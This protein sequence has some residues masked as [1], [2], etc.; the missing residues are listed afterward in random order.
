MSFDIFVITYRVTN[1]CQNWLTCY[2]FLWKKTEFPF[3]VFSCF[4]VLPVNCISALFQD[5][6]HTRE[7]RAIALASLVVVA[8]LASLLFDGG[9]FIYGVVNG[10]QRLK[11]LRDINRKLDPLNQH[12]D[13]IAADVKSLQTGQEWLEGAVLY[14]KDVQRLTYFLEYLTNSL[15]LRNERASGPQKRKQK[16]QNKNQKNKKKGLGPPRLAKE[17]VKLSLTLDLMVWAK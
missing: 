4:W 13:S 9:S 2:Y 12:L 7:K 5:G 3:F 17:W 6:V 14:G 10:Q 8:P 15:F 16:N 1:F 11:Q